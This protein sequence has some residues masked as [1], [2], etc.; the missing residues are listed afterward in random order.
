MPILAEYRTQRGE[1]EATRSSSTTSPRCSR[2]RCS[3][4]TAL[5]VAGRAAHRLP[6]RARLRA[7]A[8][9]KFD[10]TV[11][12]LRITFPYILFISLV[13]LGGGILNTYSRFAIPAF[14]PTLLNLV[15]HRALRSGC[16]PFFDPPV[17]ALA[18]AVFAGGVLQLGFQV[19]FLARL[20]CCRARA[21]LCATRACGGPPADGPGDLRRVGRR[22]SACYQHASSP[23]SW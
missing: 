9:D 19:P 13:S 18:W 1:A 3:S 12:L 14:T 20:R 6:E 2:W 17:M 16:A 22:R 21:W 11:E 4:V 8:P 15:L 10:L 5:G 23:R 7:R